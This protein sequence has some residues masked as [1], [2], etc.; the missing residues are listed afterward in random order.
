MTNNAQTDNC[1]I[2][3]ESEGLRL[4]AD[5][6]S[7]ILQACSMMTIMLL[8]FGPNHSCAGQQKKTTVILILMMC[9][10][11]PLAKLRSNDEKTPQLQLF[12]CSRALT[13]FMACKLNSEHS[14][15]NEFSLVQVFRVQ[16]LT[17]S[18]YGLIKV[19]SGSYSVLIK[20]SLRSHP[21]LIQV[22]S[23][24]H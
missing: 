18:H 5:G 3:T 14:G 20:V 12:F 16:V 19:S 17:R 9:S 8:V 24:S 1:T 7:P 13:T 23:R 22:L 11:L 6:Y 4:A 2:A 10:T 15:L 21:G